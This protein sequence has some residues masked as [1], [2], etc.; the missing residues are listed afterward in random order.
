MTR[1]N[2]K[3]IENARGVR[4]NG[5][6]PAHKKGGSPVGCGVSQKTSAQEPQFAIFS[7]DEQLSQTVHFAG[8]TGKALL[9]K[10][11]G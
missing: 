10:N 6:R 5:Q 7:A 4:T 1:A 8:L 2:R 11:V 9:C 3:N